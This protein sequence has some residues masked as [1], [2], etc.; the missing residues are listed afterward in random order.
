MADHTFTVTLEVPHAGGRAWQW[1]A[2]EFDQHLA[3][4]VIPPVLAADLV[5]EVRRGRDGLRLRIAVI[6]RADDVCQ[7]VILAWEALEAASDVGGFDL[8]GATAQAGPAPLMLSSYGPAGPHRRRP[9]WP[10]RTA[11][12]TPPVPGS[13]PRGR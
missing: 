10:Y 6:V 8:S 1:V 12:P 4:Q 5:A 11:P 3:A 9:A 2:A 7:A 13:L